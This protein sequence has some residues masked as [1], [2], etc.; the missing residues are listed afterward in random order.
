MLVILVS[1][2]GGMISGVGEAGAEAERL[3]KM[4]AVEE[5]RR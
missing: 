3:G 4:E 2:A 5:E 1:A